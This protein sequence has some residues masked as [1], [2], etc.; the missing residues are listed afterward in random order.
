MATAA[1]TECAPLLNHRCLPVAT[2]FTLAESLVFT[3]LF[4]ACE[5]WCDVTSGHM[6]KMQT[7]VSKMMRRILRQCTRG[8]RHGVPDP[9]LRVYHSAPLA[10]HYMRVARLSFLAQALCNGPGL[11][12]DM[13]MDGAFTGFEQWRA[14]LMDDAAW[15]RALVP[16]CAQLLPPE[17]DWKVLVALAQSAP[18]WKRWCGRALRL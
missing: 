9:V 2:K 1:L 16:Q 11:L 8:E 14:L 15:L 7:V 12:V 13:L 17:F 4:F 18:H 3:R 6:A 5:T 10:E